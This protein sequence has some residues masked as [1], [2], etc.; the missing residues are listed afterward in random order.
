MSEKNA[1]MTETQHSEDSSGSLHA[2]HRSLALSVVLGT[3]VAAAC[4]GA[5][6]GALS[7][8][9]PWDA[10]PTGI[11]STPLRDSQA[12]LAM[13]GD[14][15]VV[16]APRP[17]AT[18]TLPDAAVAVIPS[19]FPTG[20]TYQSAPIA[21]NDGARRVH[22]RK[23]KKPLDD[24]SRATECLGCHAPLGDAKDKE[25][26][27]AGYVSTTP[28]GDT[29]LQDAEIWVVDESGTN[30]LKTNSDESGFFWLLKGTTS[31]KPAYV[32]IR[33][34]TQTQ[35]M[36][37]RLGGSGGACSTCHKAGGPGFVNIQGD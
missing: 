17:D 16:V 27:F 14:A 34:G 12:P 24:G 26:L 10:G 6:P 9:V 1:M 19:A 3:V 15:A 7:F 25:F 2:M 32:A 8:K 22:E 28:V 18:S 20:T 30:R 33:K 23:G 5:D 11:P 35:V 31:W 13:P 36:K 21:E 29:P 37:A 4:S